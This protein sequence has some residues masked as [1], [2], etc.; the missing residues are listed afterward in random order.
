MKKVSL[1]VHKSNIERQERKLIASDMRLA[2]DE[3]VRIGNVVAYAIVCFRPD[4][5]AYCAFDSGKIMPLWAFDGACAKVIERCVA[6][7]EDDWK[8]PLRPTRM[9]K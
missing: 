2:V 8:A 4:G 5:S 9:G 3:S 6:D 1:S 7:T